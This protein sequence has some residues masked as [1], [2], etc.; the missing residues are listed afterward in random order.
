MEFFIDTQMYSVFSY[1][2]YQKFAFYKNT[3]DTESPYEIF[4]F[5][6]ICQQVTGTSR[7]LEM[8]IR[9]FN[10]TLKFYLPIKGF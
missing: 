7:V 8:E 3:K 9:T 2:F 6:G 5:L 1:S 4:S 10:T